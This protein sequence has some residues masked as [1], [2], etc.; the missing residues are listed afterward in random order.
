MSLSCVRCLGSDFTCLCLCPPLRFSL[1]PLPA[2]SLAIVSVPRS[3]SRGGPLCDR[4]RLRLS[5]AFVIRVVIG[6]RCV[7]AFLSFWFY[8]FSSS[9]FDYVL[10]SVTARSPRPRQTGGQTFSFQA[11]LVAF[12]HLCRNPLVRWGVAP[13]AM[14]A[15]GA[16]PPILFYVFTSR[17]CWFGGA[18]R[19]LPL[20]AG[21]AGPPIFTRLR[22]EL[23][24][25]AGRCAS[26]T[27]GAQGLPACSCELVIPCHV[28]VLV[29]G[30]IV[31]VPFC[32]FELARERC[33][34]DCFLIR[35][36]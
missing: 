1:A 35:A 20:R 16:G 29:L 23:V 3:S 30:A 10:M 17:T 36:D 7:F 13:P 22:L 15:G 26:L 4:G 28:P 2:P 21:G 14:R 11:F 9:C 12:A 33:H 25:S 18:L 5:L 32:F 31:Y 6:S 8:V 34:H 19:L 24:G 27:A